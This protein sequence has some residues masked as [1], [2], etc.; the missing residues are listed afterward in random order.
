MDQQGA[1]SQAITAAA[2]PAGQV[3]M[4]YE[5]GKTRFW[6]NTLPHVLVRTLWRNRALLH[7]LSKSRFSAGHREDILGMAWL[8]LEPLALLGVYSIVFLVIL[9]FKFA[10]RT[11]GEFGPLGN[12][13]SL[14][15]GIVTY[16]MFASALNASAS[17]IRTA[18]GYV[19]QMVFPTEVLPASVVGGLIVPG[20]IGYA[21]VLA[22]AAIGGL[23]VGAI[24]LALPLVL[25]PMFLLVLGLGWLLGALAVFIPDVRTLTTIVTRFGFFLTPV[26]YPLSIVKD[27]NARALL[28]LNPLTWVVEGVRSVLLRAQA[29]MWLHLGV[30]A[31]G[32]LLLCQLAFAF[33]VRSKRW[34]ADVV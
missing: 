28:M 33:F 27:A 5:G 26:V 19:K 31:V 12:T 2:R 18:Q 10:D 32:S 6:P 29:P 25:A 20:A 16:Q 15:A 22:A 3:H 30:L 4:R 24:A 9:K 17:V 13:L 8:V 34:F 23:P 7:Q 14:Y 1:T 21:I 11:G